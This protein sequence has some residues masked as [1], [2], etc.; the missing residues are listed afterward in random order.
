MNL[1]RETLRLS[2][3]DKCYFPDFHNSYEHEELYNTLYETSKGEVYIYIIILILSFL[4]SFLS[5]L[6]F[7]LSLSIIFLLYLLDENQTWCN[8]SST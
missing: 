7:L 4:F 6:N 5:L 2:K 8:T 1:K 3:S